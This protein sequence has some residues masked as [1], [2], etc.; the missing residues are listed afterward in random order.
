MAF[1]HSVPDLIPSVNM[2]S[3]VHVF[4][5]VP[6]YISHFSVKIVRECVQGEGAVG[7]LYHHECTHTKMHSGMQTTWNLGMIAV[8]RGFLLFLIFYQ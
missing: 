4:F 7:L 3:P 6:R 8:K 1:C 2:W 5:S